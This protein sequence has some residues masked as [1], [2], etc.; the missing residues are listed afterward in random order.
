MTEYR[1]E[2]PLLRFTAA[3][4]SSGDG[5]TPQLV[6]FFSTPEEAQAAHEW[7]ANAQMRLAGSLPEMATPSQ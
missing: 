1:T 6:L 7:V 2:N 5:S 4:N 3:Y